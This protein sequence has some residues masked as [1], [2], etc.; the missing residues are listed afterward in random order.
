[1]IIVMILIT[2]AR[3]RTD[4]SCASCSKQYSSTTHSNTGVVS[5]YSTWNAL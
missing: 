4:A 5:R 2:F 1:L 3:W